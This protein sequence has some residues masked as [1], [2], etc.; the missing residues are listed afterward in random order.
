MTKVSKVLNAPDWTALGTL[1][2][3]YITTADLISVDTNVDTD[4]NKVAYVIT[5]V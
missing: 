3:A 2:D 4:G 1:V 5:T